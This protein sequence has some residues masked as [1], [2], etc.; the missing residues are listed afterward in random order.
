[1]S[2]N[3]GDVLIPPD[4]SVVLIPPDIVEGGAMDIALDHSRIRGHDGERNKSERR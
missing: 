2:D 1:M 4:N 3:V